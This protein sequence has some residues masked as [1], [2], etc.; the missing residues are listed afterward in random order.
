MKKI[1][2]LFLF[3]TSFVRGND[4]QN[5]LEY[6]KNS[7]SVH[8]KVS[9]SVVSITNTQKIKRSL[10]SPVQEIPAGAGSGFVWDKLGHIV[11]NFHVTQGASEF[12]ITF[13]KDKS[14]YKAVL[15]GAEPR[16][17]IAVLKIINPPKNLIPIT[18]GN[19][20]KSM[21]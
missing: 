14:E 11:T 15:V 1:S 6:E 8:E 10:W 3:L 2:F 9:P 20:Q 12:V 18:I 5:L 4:F 13:S 16:K 17:D 21:T 7:I 19:S